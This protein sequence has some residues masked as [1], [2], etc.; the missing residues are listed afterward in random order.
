MIGD[1]LRAQPADHAR[2]GARVSR[3]V[4]EVVGSSKM[5]IRAS[6]PSALAISTSWRSPWLR[7]LTGV[8]RRHVEI[9]GVEQ[10]LRLRSRTLRRSMNGRP[11]DQL[12]GNRR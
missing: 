7:R 1:A 6:A 4:S 3:A 12:A 8:R 9:D 10:L 11:R 5:T 2:T